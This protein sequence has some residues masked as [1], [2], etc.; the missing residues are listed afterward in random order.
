MT[1]E[2]VR[3]N[4]NRSRE[5]VLNVRAQEQRKRM[6]RWRGWRTRRYGPNARYKIPRM[7]LLYW[8]IEAAAMF[9]FVR[10]NPRSVR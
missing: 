1:W 10:K 8:R 9:C 7:P 3:S 5:R 4:V 6:P 2:V